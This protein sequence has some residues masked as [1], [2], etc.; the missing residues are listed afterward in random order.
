M[1]GGGDHR[2]CHEE[3]FGVMGLFCILIVVVITQIHTSVKIYRVT[4][5]L[6][7]ILKNTIKNDLYKMFA[8]V[9]VCV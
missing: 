8:R 5:L 7:V 9:H 4:N 2:G 6:L 3:C 1:V